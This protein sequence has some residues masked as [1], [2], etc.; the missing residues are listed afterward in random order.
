MPK[1]DMSL[2]SDESG[3]LIVYKSKGQYLIRSKGRTGTQA[4]VAKEQAK[5]LGRASAVSAKLRAAFKPLMPD[6]KNRDTMYRLN[7]VL[8]QWLRTNPQQINESVNTVYQLNGFALNNHEMSASLY[9]GM[10]VVRDESGNVSLSVPAFDSPNPIHPL[11]FDGVVKLHIIA[12]SCN[13][14]DPANSLSTET[15]REIE[16]NGTPVPSQL[17]Q[18]NTR[19]QQG[20][21]TVVALA[22]NEAAAGIVGA[23]WN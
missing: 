6:V 19:P 16:Y 15:I 10:P 14:N 8:Q 13:L 12:V 11:P 2:L 18:L 3:P 5:I 4:P 20:Y 22:V 23:M 21:L 9:T 7:N 1:I 17:V